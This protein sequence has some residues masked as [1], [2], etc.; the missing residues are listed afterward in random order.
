MPVRVLHLDQSSLQ[1]EL[2]GVDQLAQR[3]Q[4]L[5][6]RALW[7]KGEGEEG[8]GP[9]V[10]QEQAGNGGNQDAECT[11]VAC[12]DRLPR[13]QQTQTQHK[14]PC[15]LTCA[16]LLSTTSPSAPIL[17][18]MSEAVEAPAWGTLNFS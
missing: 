1:G 5:T 4:Q 8:S 18:G 10:W 17:S 13:K 7:Q 9:A 16:T 2:R 3:T 12:S 6:P 11:A 15:Q 14:W